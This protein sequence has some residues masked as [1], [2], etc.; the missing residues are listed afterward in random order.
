[1]QSCISP[2]SDGKGGKEQRRTILV[3]NT[4]LRAELEDEHPSQGSLPPG[5]IKTEDNYPGGAEISFVKQH[6]PLKPRSSQGH[7]L[8][9]YLTPP[10]H[11][12]RHSGKRAGQLDNRPQKRPCLH[13][14]LSKLDTHTEKGQFGK[15]RYIPGA[16]TKGEVIMSSSLLPALPPFTSVNICRKLQSCSVF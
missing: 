7:F 11:S 6:F 5:L 2:V 14:A 16:K 10:K 3:S 1:M 12:K 8:A 13:V 4:F 15:K 9:M